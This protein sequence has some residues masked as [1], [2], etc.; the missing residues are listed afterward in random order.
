[1]CRVNLSQSQTPASVSAGTEETWDAEYSIPSSGESLGMALPAKSRRPDGFPE[2]EHSVVP[3]LPPLVEDDSTVGG[4]DDQG[5]A[6]EIEVD[7]Q[8]EVEDLNADLITMDRQFDSPGPASPTLEAA[9]DQCAADA[10]FEI[11]TKLDVLTIVP[12]TQLPSPRM[13]PRRVTRQ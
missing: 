10:S 8:Q 7:I 6:P 11:G 9:L 4:T 13:P 3:Y 5:M 12:S 1:M 2:A